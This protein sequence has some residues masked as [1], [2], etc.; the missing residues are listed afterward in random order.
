MPGLAEL[1]EGAARVDVRYQDLGDGAT[2]TY[3]TA[4][5]KLIS[6]IHS[7]FDAQSTDHG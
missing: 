4:E 5:E 3:T 6:G 7:W 1:R 2:L